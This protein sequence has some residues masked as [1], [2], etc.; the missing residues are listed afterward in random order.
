MSN[1]GQLTAP[2][3]QSTTTQPATQLETTTGITD[4]SFRSLLI[5]VPVII[6][7]LLLLLVVL[8]LILWRCKHHHTAKEEASH[9]TS[10]TH[11][12]V[13]LCEETGQLQY[14]SDQDNPSHTYSTL[15]HKGKKEKG[16]GGA[17]QDDA[18]FSSIQLEATNKEKNKMSSKKHSTGKKKPHGDNSQSST[19]GRGISLRK[20]ME[21]NIN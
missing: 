9:T 21:S 11:S 19:S 2:G 10:H 13:S 7:F 17:Y 16:R 6:I 4:N 14:A 3:S 8:V 5:V 20:K 15:Q 12:A 18:T 1:G